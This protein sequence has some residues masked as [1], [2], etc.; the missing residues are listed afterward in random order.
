MIISLNKMQPINYRNLLSNRC[1]KCNKYLWFDGSEDML[2]C[3]YKCGFMIDKVKM[4][5]IC[6]DMTVKK[7]ESYGF[8]DEV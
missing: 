5:S 8:F 3:T 6:V 7:V 1:P 2:I 4:E